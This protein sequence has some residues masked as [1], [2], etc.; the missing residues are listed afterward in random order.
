MF[1]LMLLAL[2]TSGDGADEDRHEYTHEEFLELSLADLEE[3]TGVIRPK[4]STTEKLAE[5]RERAWASYRQDVSN[6]DEWGNARQGDTELPEA[7]PADEENPDQDEYLPE[8]GEG[9]YSDE[10]LEE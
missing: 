4:D 3:L 10:L 6:R 2:T 1:Q 5:Y 8:D 7:E 9:Y